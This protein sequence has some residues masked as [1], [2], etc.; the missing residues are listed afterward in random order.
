MLSSDYAWLNKAKC[1]YIL[2][3][4]WTN[5]Y[6]SIEE[7]P[8]KFSKTSKVISGRG[9]DTEATSPCPILIMLSAWLGSDKYQPLSHWC[10]STRVWTHGFESYDLPKCETDAQL[11]RPQIDRT[12]IVC[13]HY[14]RTDNL[15]VDPK[16]DK[17]AILGTN[18]A[19]SAVVWLVKSLH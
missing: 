1:H 2:R 15:S 13:V 5:M 6:W 4:R 19:R 18:R 14:N 8:C 10:D 17:S 11:I 3:N 16:P 9:S 7:I 12:L